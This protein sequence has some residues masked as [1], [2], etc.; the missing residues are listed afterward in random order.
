M[1]EISSFSNPKFKHLKSLSKSKKRKE[2]GVFLVEGRVEL[3]VALRAGFVP[4]EVVYAESYIDLEELSKLCDLDRIEL[5]RLTK[6]LFDDLTY[7]NVP[8]N[9]LAIFQSWDLGLDDLKDDS[10]VVVLEGIEKP[11]NLGAVLRSCDAAG[12]KNVLLTNSEIDLFNPNVIRNSRGAL[13][14]TRVVRATNEKALEYLQFKGCEVYAA[15]L[16]PNAIDYRLMSNRP[17][18]LVF[19]A[20]STG[21]SDFWLN[22]TSKQIIIPMRGAV[23]SLNLSVSLAVIL[24]HAISI[25]EV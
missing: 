21:L 17:K 8:G 18:A 2:D 19:G 12:I 5:L 7:Q 14:T 16:T 24:F 9:F 13:F 23:D 11:G 15:A 6:S 3:E 1:I 25:S 10:I 22:E 20:E 4:T